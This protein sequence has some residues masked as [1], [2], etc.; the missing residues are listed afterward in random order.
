VSKV[1]AIGKLKNDHRDE[2]FSE[3]YLKFEL[4]ENDK[5]IKTFFLEHPLYKSV[6]YYD[7][8]KFV[9]KDV[10]LKR[11]EFFIRI[12]INDNFSNSIRISESIKKSAVKELINFKL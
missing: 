1:K 9:R 5:R 3:S 11:D 12:Q 4:M 7:D 2:I 6:E 8:K 10:E